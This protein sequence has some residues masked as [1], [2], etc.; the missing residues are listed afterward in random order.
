[1]AH[2]LVSAI[3]NSF[4]QFV[5]VAK[6]PNNIQRLRNDNSVSKEIVTTPVIMMQELIAQLQ[7]AVLGNSLGSL[8]ASKPLTYILFFP[9]SERQRDDSDKGSPSVLGARNGKKGRGKSYKKTQK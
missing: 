5:K 6:H 2:T 9:D 8:F 3:F 4:A 7:S 1:M